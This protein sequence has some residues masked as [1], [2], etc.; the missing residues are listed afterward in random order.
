MY[1]FYVRAT[2]KELSMLVLR[3]NGLMDENIQAFMEAL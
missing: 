3:A 2:H 1:I